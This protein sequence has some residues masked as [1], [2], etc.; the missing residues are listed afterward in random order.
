MKPPDVSIDNN[1]VLTAEA[2]VDSMAIYLKLKDRYR[3]RNSEG[4]VTKY[5]EVNKLT[6]W[7]DIRI[8]FA[9]IVL[10]LIPLAVIYGY[11]SKLFTIIKK[12]LK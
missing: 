1:N 7:Q 3:E 2:K 10:L 11:R 9:N 6:S 12:I 8:K 4:T 5:I